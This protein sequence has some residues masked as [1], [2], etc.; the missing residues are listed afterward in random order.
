VTL[1]QI[2]LNGGTL[3]QTTM[4]TL[5]GSTKTYLWPTGMDAGST[6][7]SHLTL[8]YL[9]GVVQLYL[10]GALVLTTETQPL[11]YSSIGAIVYIGRK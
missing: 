8:V 2:C 9:R 10:D 7:E 3:I 6:L 5:D 1:L 11:S 4:T